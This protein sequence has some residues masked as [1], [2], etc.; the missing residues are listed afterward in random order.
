MNLLWIWIRK[1]ERQNKK[2]DRSGD[3]GK[4]PQKRKKKKKKRRRCHLEGF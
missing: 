4:S 3:F 1:T 2:L